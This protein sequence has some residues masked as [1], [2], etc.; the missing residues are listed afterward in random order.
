[1]IADT[2]AIPT[3]THSRPA[4]EKRSSSRVTTSQPPTSHAPCDLV[5][6]I[7]RGGTMF[8]EL[9]GLSADENEDLFEV[10]LAD[11]DAR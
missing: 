11:E 2:S 1:V 6:D 8:Q 4:A 3:A 9:A 5:V 10:E 7:P